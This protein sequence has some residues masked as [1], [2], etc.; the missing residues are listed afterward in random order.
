[1]GWEVRASA[2]HIHVRPRQ[3]ADPAGRKA[4]ARQQLLFGRNDQLS[5]DSHRRFLFGAERPSK[6]SSCKPM[7]DLI[8]LDG[9]R[10]G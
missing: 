5:E 3:P 10:P 9:R 6:Y 7:T 4:L 2:H 1:M 8:A